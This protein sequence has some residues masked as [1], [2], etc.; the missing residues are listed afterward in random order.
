MKPSAHISPSRERINKKSNW[1][2]L[3]ALEI[4]LNDLKAYPFSSIIL[5]LSFLLSLVNSWFNSKN[6]SETKPIYKRLTMN[7]S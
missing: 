2:G 7:S 3:I 5:H 6:S 1:S 4:F